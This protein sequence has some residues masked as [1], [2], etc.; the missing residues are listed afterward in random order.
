MS[1]VCPI[2]IV[3]DDAHLRLSLLEQLTFHHE[4]HASE[5]ADVAQALTIVRGA[6]RPGDHGCRSSGRRWARV[7]KWLRAGGFQKPIIL[8]T[9]HDLESDVVHGLDSEPMITSASRSGSLFCWRAFAPISASTNSATMRL[10]NRPYIFHPGAKLLISKGAKKL[11]LT[12]KET[13]ILQYLKLRQG[14]R[15]FARR[16]AARRMGI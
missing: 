13:A 5:A 3:D 11:R 9:G 4:F 7:V 2:L 12:E 14:R 6:D 16:S 1:L 15:G 8:L 10:S